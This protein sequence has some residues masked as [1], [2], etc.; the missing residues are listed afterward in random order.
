MKT[1]EATPAISPAVSGRLALP[2]VLGAFFLSGFAALL[3][4][5]IWQRIL[6][7]FSGAD[8]YSVTVTVGAFMAGLGC[9]S[10]AG[11]HIADRLRRG[12]A[13]ALFGLSEL[14]VAGFALISK[15]FY[16]D[17][18]YGQHGYLARDP[19]TM[20][21]VLFLSMLFP[22]FFMGMSL[23]LL[24]RAFAATVEA[25]PGTIGALYGIN[26]LGAAAGS[27]VTTWFL[28]RRLD[29]ESALQVG[30]ALNLVC[31]ATAIPLGLLAVPTAPRTPAPTE[32]H[33]PAT[34]LGF[35]VWAAV[36]GLSGFINLS[37]EI[38]WFRLLSTMLK[39]T[40]FT[41]GTLLAIYL[42]GL[43]L[44]TLAGIGLVGRSRHPARTFLLLEAGV[45]AYALVSV[46]LLVGII[47][48]VPAL[49]PLWRYFGEYEPLDV[50]QAIANLRAYLL[51]LAPF[52]PAAD[53]L[54]VKFLAIY[55]L[56]PAAIVG[57]PTLLMGLSFPFLQKATQTD[58][59]KVG[60]RVGWLQTANIAGSLVGTVATGTVL[61]GTLGTADTLRLLVLF[62]GVSLL[63]IGF[64]AGT[65]TPPVRRVP[66][67]VGAAGLGAAAL[68]GAPRAE[69]LWAKLHGTTPDRVV[70]FED[71][72]GL[73]LIKN[74]RPDFTGRSFIFANGR[75]ESWVPFGGTHTLLGVLPAMLHPAP[76]ELAVIGLG[77]GDTL[78]NIASRPETTRVTCIEIVASQLD[79]VRALAARQ[80]YR[81][82]QLLWSDPRIE[83]V[84]GDGRTYLARSGRKFDIIEADAL[85]PNS[86]YAGYLYSLEYFTLMRERLKPGGLAVTWVPTLRT[87]DTFVK[88]FP[89][90]VSFGIILV[91]SNEPIVVDRAAIERRLSDPFVVDR[92]RDSGLDIPG[93]LRWLLDTYPPAFIGPDFDRSAIT[94]VNRDLQPKDEFMVAGRAP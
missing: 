10:L 23:P 32:P 34:G 31:A 94:D 62:G 69:L 9:G 60:R 46:A 24:S 66:W 64:A 67:L 48:R 61:L 74:E 41:F 12:W 47:D 29:F 6:V 14:S 56:L 42:G 30:A 52:D 16:Y 93:G 84:V 75:G 73:S 91:G 54:T 3:Y 40:A 7:V 27:L 18:L 2:V 63:V 37:L 5:V 80:P 83:L 21:V 86:A 55:F 70:F 8:V 13:L 58:A 88:A 72:S 22:T 50:G 77:S 45:G 78:F 19:L 81:P 57:P 85:R 90:V 17:F 44:G 25:A 92:Y 15:T 59:E 87:H 79:A 11:G 89:Y 39:A 20:G 36:Y 43:A 4:Q 49:A 28:L 33:R 53:R 71:G 38:L 68:F 51:G 65:G 1:I 76:R 26:T 35:G 82:L